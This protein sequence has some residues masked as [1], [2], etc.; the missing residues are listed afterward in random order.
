MSSQSLQEVS[1]S[2]REELPHI[3]AEVHRIVHEVFPGLRFTNVWVQPTRSWYGDE[4]VDVWAI[5][6]GE[7]EAQQQVEGL[8]SFRRRVRDLLWDQDLEVTP[9]IH[10]ITQSDAGDWRPGGL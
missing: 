10:L 8:T 7:V 6:E 3:R 2:L 5:Y 1:R 4:V 9:S